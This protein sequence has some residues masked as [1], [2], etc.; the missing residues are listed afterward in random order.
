VHVSRS[1][2][3]LEV[4]KGWWSK[5]TIRQRTF[6]QRL[7]EKCFGPQDWCPYWH[8][9]VR[10][11]VEQLMGEAIGQ[12]SLM[13]NWVGSIACITA[14]CVHSKRETQQCETHEPPSKDGPWR[15]YLCFPQ[16][17]RQ[18]QRDLARPLIGVE[19]VPRA[20]A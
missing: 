14:I 3:V 9:T 18:R 1:K 12:H 10:M 15:R 8:D 16:R 2:G 11:G 6:Q 20:R 17:Q 13:V 19:N 4:R 5:P 7:L